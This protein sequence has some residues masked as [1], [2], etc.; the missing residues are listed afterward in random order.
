[1]RTSRT[2]RRSTAPAE[3]RRFF[4][5][6]LGAGSTS[7]V[8]CVVGHWVTTPFGPFADVMVEDDEGWRTLLAPT[9]EI[10]EFVC[11]TYDFD[12]VVVAPVDVDA[13]GRDGVVTGPGRWS[14]R[15]PDLALDLQVAGRPLLGQALRL[16]PL[17]A[18]ASPVCCRAVDPVA[19]LVLPGVRTYGTALA[20]R[21]E[22]YGALD[23]HRVVDLRGSWRGRSLGV[24]TP[25]E[26]P[27]RFG[28]SS[29]PATPACVRVVTTIDEQADVKPVE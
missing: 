11:G 4:G 29:T 23:L 20:G 6:I 17:A 22:A 24:L 25:V 21:H 15:T 5:H 3:R 9:D 12:E 28:F 27:V 8:R 14:V 18:A 10:A 19:R 13:P 2:F 16:V 26:P 7:G 1:M